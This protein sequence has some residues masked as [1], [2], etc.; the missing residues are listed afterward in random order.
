MGLGGRRR[1]GTDDVFDAEFDSQVVHPTMSDEKAEDNGEFIERL[2]DDGAHTGLIVIAPHGGDI[3]E[4]TDDQ[5]QRVAY[6]LADKPV[7]FWLCKGYQGRAAPRKPGTSLPRT[8]I[9]QAFPGSIRSSARRFSHAVAFHG[10]TRARMILVGGMASP[11]LKERSHRDQPSRCRIEHF[12]TDRW[13]RRCFRR[14][15]PMQHREP[16]HHR[17]SKRRPDRAEPDGANRHGAE[18]AEAVAGVYGLRLRRPRR[19]GSF[20]RS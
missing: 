1:L 13:S 9:R 8:S 15:R 7:S 19:C 14:R 18:I 20:R 3:E 12:R 16:A 6:S 11:A 5:A 2:H 10:F 4:H 17:R